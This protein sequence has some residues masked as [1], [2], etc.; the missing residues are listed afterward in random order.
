MTEKAYRFSPS[1]IDKLNKH[2]GAPRLSTRQFTLF[3]G[4]PGC[5]LLPLYVQ[6]VW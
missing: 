6:I 4:R 3:D 1:A 2:R 5:P